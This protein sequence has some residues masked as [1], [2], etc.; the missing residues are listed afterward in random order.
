MKRQASDSFSSSN[1]LVVKRQ[2]SNSNIQDGSVVAAVG[3]G[4]KDGA[5]IPSVRGPVLSCFTAIMAEYLEQGQL[6]GAMVLESPNER[7]T[8]T[9]Y[10]VDR[11]FWGNLRLSI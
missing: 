4:G 3:K 11:T 8:G 2:K 7:P 9:H 5:L 10:G 1:Q 6:I